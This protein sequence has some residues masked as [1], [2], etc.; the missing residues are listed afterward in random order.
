M[1]LAEYYDRH[2]TQALADLANRSGTRLSYLRQLIYAPEKCPSLK[3]A[4]AI[5]RA[6]NGEISYEE[7]AGEA[8][9]KVPEAA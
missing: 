5:V 8:P 1:T 3:M 6:S 2:G 9:A 7:L 4:V